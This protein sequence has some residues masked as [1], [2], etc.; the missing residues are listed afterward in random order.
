MIE[1]RREDEEIENLVRRL[2]GDWKVT[3]TV[4]KPDGSIST[5]KG[6]VRTADL[7]S[8]RGIR[9]TMELNV[10][11]GRR[12]SEDNLWAIDPN[13]RKVHNYSIKSDGS[14]HDHVGQW[15]DDSNLELHW[16]G[17]YHD[18]PVMED[19]EY[20]WVSPKEIRVHKIDR[21]EGEEV[22]VSDYVLR[23]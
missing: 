1:E 4:N 8:R 6:K 17:T 3:V 5:G 2:K 14:V 12:Y 10:D 9:G 21:S 16:E 23:R 13:T 15:K 11:G 19:Y 18:R 7:S 22:F 20:N